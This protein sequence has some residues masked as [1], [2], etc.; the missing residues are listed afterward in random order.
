M[1]EGFEAAIAV[2]IEKVTMCEFYAGIYAGVQ[3]PSPLGST[4]LRSTQLPKMLSSALPEFYATV[5]VFLVKVHS[6]FED[7]GTNTYYL[8]YQVY[9]I[10]YCEVMLNK[11]SSVMKKFISTLKS[12]NYKFQPLIEEMNTKEEAISKCA[13]ATTMDRI[14]GTILWIHVTRYSGTDSNPGVQRLKVLFRVGSLSVK[15]SLSD[16]YKTVK[17]TYRLWLLKHYICRGKSTIMSRV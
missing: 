8:E 12:F 7:G 9:K 1:I 4:Q 5:I 10:Y 3:L 14:R 15:S 17:Q 16:A 11:P 13:N 6:Y 2:L